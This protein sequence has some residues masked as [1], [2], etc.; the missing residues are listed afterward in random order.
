[1]VRSWLVP[2]AESRVKL[3]MM[4]VPVSTVVAP[5]GR[6]SKTI[7]QSAYVLRLYDGIINQV[8]IKSRAVHSI[9]FDTY[10]IQL[11]LKKAMAKGKNRR[12]DEKEMGIGELHGYLQSATPDDPRYYIMLIEYH[13]KFSIPFACI[14]LGFLAVPIGIHAQS[15]RRSF[16]LGLGLIF[17]LGYYL[18]LSAG[19]VF[20][21]AGVYPPL[22]GMWMPNLV[23]GGLG[24]YLLVRAVQE[25]PVNLTAWAN[26]ARHVLARI[27]PWQQSGGKP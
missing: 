21:E 12:K 23:M 5:R 7:D 4:F 19:I 10:N 14:A 27:R 26:A 1:M 11:S 8:N 9:H 17:F 25:R 20:G 2:R 16:G 22:V 18:M 24:V 13:K 6:L 15:A 3:K